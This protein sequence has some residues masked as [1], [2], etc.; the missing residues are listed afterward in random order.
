MQKLIELRSDFL[1]NYFP[2]YSCLQFIELFLI[3]NVLRITL[4]V[5][6]YFSFISLFPLV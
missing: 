6:L 2:V 3:V 1:S 4:R 5:N